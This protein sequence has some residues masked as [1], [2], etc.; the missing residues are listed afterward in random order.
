MKRSSGVKKDQVWIAKPEFL[1][2]NKML[3]GQFRKLLRRRAL[4]GSELNNIWNVVCPYS[5]ARSE[6]FN[7]MV[8][9]GSM[10]SSSIHNS[11]RL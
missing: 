5:R 7:N 10:A 4:D 11:R 6:T 2:E 1:K 3:I 8:Q 9:L